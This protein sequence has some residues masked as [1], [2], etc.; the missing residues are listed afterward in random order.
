[1]CEI[2]SRLK[3]VAKHFPGGTQDITES[4]LHVFKKKSFAVNNGH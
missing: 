2:H 3:E 1:M 4:N